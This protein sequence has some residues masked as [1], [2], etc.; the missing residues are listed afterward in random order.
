M[1]D[2]PVDPLR[3]WLVEKG[4]RTAWFN[5]EETRPIGTGVGASFS[6]ISRRSSAS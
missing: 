3:I 5:Y 1:D 2:A 6:G 4:N